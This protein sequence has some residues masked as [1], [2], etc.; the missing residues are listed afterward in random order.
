VP[1]G[2]RWDSCPMSCA[3]GSRSGKPGRSKAARCTSIALCAALPCVVRCRASFRS[4]RPLRGDEFSAAN[5]ANGSEANIHRLPMS[6]TS[7][8]RLPCG[9]W[10]VSC[11]SRTFAARLSAALPGQLSQTPLAGNN[12][13]RRFR[14]L[15]AARVSLGKVGDS[16]WAISPPA[17]RANPRAFHLGGV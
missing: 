11:T 8:L 5:V 7:L 10:G 3:R 16:L 9:G 12:D 13:R 6:Q 2:A 4:D 14:S 17:I 1:S 15:S